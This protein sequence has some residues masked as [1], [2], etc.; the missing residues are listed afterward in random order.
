[1]VKKVVKAL[2][3]HRSNICELV[4]CIK[5]V[6]ERERVKS[7]LWKYRYYNYDILKYDSAVGNISLIQCPTFDTLN[8]PIVGDSL[9]IKVDGTT[10]VIKSKGQIY[11]NKWQFVASDYK[12]FNIAEAKKRT[13][14]W[15]SIPNIKAHKAKIGYLKYWK[16]LLK[17]NNIPL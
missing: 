1:M 4:Q 7:I 11:H 14:L 13:E 6:K 5:D 12:G 9:C 16:E 3:V 8:E 2:Y 10:K 15:N 17:A